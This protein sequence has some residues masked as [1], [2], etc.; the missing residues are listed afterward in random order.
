MSTL[1]NK[2]TFLLR[3]T[4]ALADK[5]D[6]HGSLKPRNFFL[7]KTLNFLLL[8]IYFL[9]GFL[10]ICFLLKI[11]IYLLERWEGKQK[12]SVTSM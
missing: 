7:G 12:E 6:C 4:L 1:P 9:N 11:F 2:N 10:V 5:Q 8:I 3:P